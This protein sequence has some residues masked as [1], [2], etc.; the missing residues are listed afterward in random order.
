MYMLYMYLIYTECVSNIYT[1]YI[2]AGRGAG[3]GGRMRTETK[4]EI[5]KTQQKKINK[6]HQRGRTKRPYTYYIMLQS[7]HL[8]NPPLPA[9]KTN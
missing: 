4:A 6:I 7:I 1:E 5:V 9:L 3:G 2:E 8:Q